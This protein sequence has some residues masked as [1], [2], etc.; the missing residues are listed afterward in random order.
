MQH[1]CI[2]QPPSSALMIDLD[3][4]LHSKNTGK[5]DADVAKR[6]PHFKLDEWEA[7]IFFYEREDDLNVY[8]ASR[9]ETA[10]DSDLSQLECNHIIWAIRG[11]Q[12][13]TVWKNY[14]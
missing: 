6:L 1:L 5:F 3:L 4:T 12:D 7:P 13:L 9:F 2:Y 10:K 8:L 14:Q 11:N